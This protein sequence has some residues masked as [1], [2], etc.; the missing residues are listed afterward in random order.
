[1]GLQILERE[2]RIFKE[3]PDIQP[4]L[5]GNEYVLERQLKPEARKDIPEL[6]RKLGVKPTA[7]I[8]ISDGLSSESMHLC[9]SSNLGIHLYEEKFPIDPN[10]FKLCEEF[11]LNATTIALNGGEDYE[12]LFTI[13]IEDHDKIKG[14]PHLSV[15]GH[16]VSDTK[17]RNLVTRDGKYLPL[18]AQGWS[19]FA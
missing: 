10:V 18:S 9:K 11:K 6:L 5:G 2:K 15:I 14:N 1:M 3:N 8:D 16:M 7:M 17:E 13:P 19:S 12:L 4:E